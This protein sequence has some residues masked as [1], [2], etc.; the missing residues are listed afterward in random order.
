MSGSQQVGTSQ[1]KSARLEK[2]RGDVIVQDLPG[3]NSG[4]RLRTFSR[5]EGDGVMLSQDEPTQT[6]FMLS[7][8][9]IEEKEA[10]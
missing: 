6:N 7:S 5:E 2:K 9:I 1:R 10:R 4:E 3:L 8:N